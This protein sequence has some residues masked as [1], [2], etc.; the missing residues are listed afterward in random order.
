MLVSR[1]GDQRFGRD[2]SIAFPAGER[3]GESSFE[4]EPRK[5]KEK[6]RRT[7]TSPHPRRIPRPCGRGL[8]DSPR[9]PPDLTLR[10][11]TIPSG[12][13]PAGSGGDD[14][15]RR[16]SLEPMIR[17]GRVE[18]SHRLFALDS[19]EQVGGVGGRAKERVS[20]RTGRGWWFHASNQDG[21]CSSVFDIPCR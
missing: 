4:G 21:R 20:G 10:T 8:R 5:K 13:I 11:G 19:V 14:R 7:R 12:E 6:D 16:S 2:Y 9:N 3:G 18:L 15:P 17:P 1:H